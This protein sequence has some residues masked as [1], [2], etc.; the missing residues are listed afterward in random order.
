MTLTGKSEKSVCSDGIVLHGIALVYMQM[1]LFQIGVLN[2]NSTINLGVTVNTLYHLLSPS[3]CVSI[4]GRSFSE[5]S[6][7]FK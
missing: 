1:C 7:S 4:G 3:T 5:G 6:G 2:E